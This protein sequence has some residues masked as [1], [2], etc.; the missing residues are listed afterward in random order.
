MTRFTMHDYP[1]EQV[2]ATKQFITR[3]FAGEATDRP[4]ALVHPKP[5]D[6]PEEAPPAGLDE[7]QLA[8]WRAQQA[9]LRRPLGGDDF[10]PTLGTGAGTCAMATAFG[11]EETTASGVYWVAPCITR[12]EEIDTLRKP[13]LTAGKL[14]RVL[15][16]TRA[17]AACADERMPIRDMDFQ[18]PFTT[19]EQ[20]LGS[21]QFF[22]MP[23][24]EPKRLHALMDV[25]TDYTIDFFTAQKAA[26][27]ANACM[28]GWPCFWFPP[29]AGIQMSDDNL[30]NVSPDVYVEFVVPYNNRIAE[31]FGGMFLHSCTI[32][33][34]D[35]PALKQIKGLTG[36]N[37]DI[38]TSVSPARLLE[39]F[40][41]DI[42]VAPHAYINT[43]TNFQNYTEF[44][45]Y[46]LATWQP[47]KRLFIYPCSV[48][49]IPDTAKEIP[50]NEA[51]TRAVLERYPGWVRDHGVES[52]I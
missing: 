36:V 20:M 22:L 41:D 8:V 24:D 7:W 26:A 13:A 25:V 18:S 16:Q 34:A 19:I 51:E 33:D 35:L 31:A 42:V 10:V 49:Y 37:C 52:M 45:E 12:M 39:E 3:L 17:Y 5:L 6:R 9:L 46:N 1:W 15:E 2:E 30:C 23:Y 21:D 47:G 11:C 50:F 40:G 48:L 28:G 38:S 43:D 44:M 4:A 27:G 14:G 29:N 32:K